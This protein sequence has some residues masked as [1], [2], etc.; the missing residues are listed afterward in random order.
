ME[1]K[2]PTKAIKEFKAGCKDNF[3][4]SLDPIK[5]FHSI[6]TLQTRKQTT[7]NPLIDGPITFARSLYPHAKRVEHQN[8]RYNNLPRMKKAR[9]VALEMYF[10]FEFQCP[11]ALKIVIPSIIKV[12]ADSDLR[13][14]PFFLVTSETRDTS[15]GI[16]ACLFIDVKNQEVLMTINWA[17]CWRGSYS[18]DD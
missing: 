7:N 13:M 16:P 14:L 18:P 4:H 11:Q 9:D 10:N 17:G 5:W 6:R 2:N 15:N 12:C 1:Q 3:L 8:I